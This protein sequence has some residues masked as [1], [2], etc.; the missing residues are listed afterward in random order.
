MKC[1]LLMRFY[2][3]NGAQQTFCRAALVF[4]AS[5]FIQ[6]A[7]FS[8][9]KD[10]LSTVRSRR[11]TLQE[12]Q[13]KRQ[14]NFQLTMPQTRML[15]YYLDKYIDFTCGGPFFSREGLFHNYL[16]SH[17]VSF[18]ERV[19]ATRCGDAHKAGLLTA[20]IVTRKLR[21]ENKRALLELL[22]QFWDFQDLERQVPT[23]AWLPHKVVKGHECLFK[24]V[25]HPEALGVMVT[26]VRE[27]TKNGLRS[28]EE[29]KEY[30][31]DWGCAYDS[32]TFQDKISVRD[33]IVYDLEAFGPEQI[34][35]L[36][37]PIF[38]RWN[39]HCKITDSNEVEALISELSHCPD[40]EDYVNSLKIVIPAVAEKYTKRSKDEIDAFLARLDCVLKQQ[41]LDLGSQDVRE[42]GRHHKKKCCIQ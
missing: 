18:N 40:I 15:F 20:A 11:N 2:K 3:N 8:Q 36:Q 41:Q 16:V 10:A 23:P 6:S 24:N 37:H 19:R 7:L 34:I 33:P 31:V 35:F 25:N 5:V 28:F 38:K 22:L 12:M 14:K 13:G 42:Q 32:V 1:F 4:C 21:A 26:F 27:V 30:L 9:Q 39:E 29:V 17:I